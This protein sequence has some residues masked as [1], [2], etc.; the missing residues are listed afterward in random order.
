M[1]MC[2]CACVCVVSI[3]LDKRNIPLGQFLFQINC[4]IFK[5]FVSVL[6]IEVS[7]TV[8]QRNKGLSWIQ[9]NRIFSLHFTYSTAFTDLRYPT[10]LK[11]KCF[12]NKFKIFLVFL[13]LYSF[14]ENKGSNS[15]PVIPF[16]TFIFYDARFETMSIGSQ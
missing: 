7:R 8:K 14:N 16:V 12:I 4:K 10:K 5:Y 9:L 11:L 2:T 1:C 3:A 13:F 6:E 15:F